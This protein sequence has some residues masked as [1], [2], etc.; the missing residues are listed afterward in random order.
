MLPD[1]APLDRRRARVFTE[2]VADCRA[3]RILH[4]VEHSDDARV[5]AASDTPAPSIAADRRLRTR[6]SRD[7]DGRANLAVC[8]SVSPRRG[9]TGPG[10]DGPSGTLPSRRGLV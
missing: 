9:E 7:R 8:E 5:S 3:N 10:W 6:R 4:T 2:P 1:T